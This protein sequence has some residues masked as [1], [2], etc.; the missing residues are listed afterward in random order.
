[1]QSIN[2]DKKR[3]LMET[4]LPEAGKGGLNITATATGHVFA[5]YQL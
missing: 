3:F 5:L 2:R 4:E 1:M